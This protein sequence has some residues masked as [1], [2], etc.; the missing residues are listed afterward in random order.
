MKC[1]IKL[2]TNNKT[3][4]FRKKSA[5][6]IFF[7]FFSEAVPYLLYA[8]FNLVKFTAKHGSTGGT[9]VNKLWARF[10]LKRGQQGVPVTP[11]SPSPVEWGWGESEI[12]SPAW[13]HRL[14]WVRGSNLGKQNMEMIN[15]FI[16]QLKLN[17]E[18]THVP[19]VPFFNNHHD[20]RYTFVS[21]CLKLG[22]L[23]G[24]GVFFLADTSIF[25]MNYKKSAA[26]E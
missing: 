12:S 14:W 26:E 13:L 21:K 3:G 25:C 6:F 5:H 2:S 9:E 19:G 20:V 4:N 22:L 17:L 15:W 11:P 10:K 24:Q 1:R 16:L 18:F 23:F 7:L 8:I